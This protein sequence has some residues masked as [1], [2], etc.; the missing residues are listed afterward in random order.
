MPP[1]RDLHVVGPSVTSGCGRSGIGCV[2]ALS[3][4][5]APVVARK[6]A[7]NYQGLRGTLGMPRPI[8]SSVTIER[9]IEAV[10]EYHASLANPGFCLDCG[11]DAD[12]CEPDMEDGTCEGCEGN[13]VHGAEQCLL[14][15]A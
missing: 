6:I 15:L 14:I 10:E 2:H 9:V 4:P 11:E 5:W 13:R 3:T 8:H 1:Y 7:R 12:G